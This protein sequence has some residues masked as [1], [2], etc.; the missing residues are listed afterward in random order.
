VTL[1]ARLLL[2][3]ALLPAAVL[4]LVLVII[5]LVLGRLLLQSVDRGLTLQAASESV[6][7][8]DRPGQDAHLHF[9]D[10]SLA[11]DLRRQGHQGALY[12]PDGARLRT[13]PPGSAAPERLG[14]DA[15]G[16][17]PLLRTT[18]LASGERVREMAVAIVSP[19]GEPHALWLAVSLEA[20]DAALAAYARVAALVGALAT[21]VLLLVQVAHARNLAARVQR[22]H[23]H[24]QRIRD[25]NFSS[26]PAVDD[27]SDVIGL[28]RGAIADATEKLRTA[29]LGQQRLVADAAHEL[30]TPLTAIRMEIDV[31]LRRERSN[32]ELA[33]ALRRVRQ[34]VDR[35]GELATHLLDLARLRGA[36][37]ERVPADAARIVDEAID[38]VRALGERRGVGL[39][40]HGLSAAPLRANPEPLRQAIDNLLVNAIKFSPAGASVDVSVQDGD[41]HLAIVVEDR[42]PGVPADHR[43][44]IFAPFHRLQRTRDGAGLGLAIVR[45]VAE[46]HGGRAWVREREGGGAAFH[47]MISKIGERPL[48]G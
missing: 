3:G 39:R 10:S 36:E 20:T 38:G 34:E 14:R 25:G 27:G 22:L 42:G 5:G 12:G 29:S 41:T 7:M 45:D 40:R 21:L 15:V 35:L 43:E 9:G 26:A 18:T 1:R 46:A 4:A 48:H 47:L 8:F 32:D 2:Y 24:M 44:A 11:G 23:V 30:R 19:R 33:E 28:L 13:F 37:W 31:T 6:S 16:P 17:A